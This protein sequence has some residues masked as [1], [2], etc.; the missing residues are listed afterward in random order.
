MAVG[1][2]PMYY[3]FAAM[4][5]TDARESAAGATVKP[6]RGRERNRS[7][8]R[9]NDGARIDATESLTKVGSIDRLAGREIM[10]QM[11]SVNCELLV[12]G[13]GPCGSTAAAL[14]RK[15][16]LSVILAEKD[17][18]PRFHIGE[19][20]LPMANGIL[21]ESGAWPKV[22][23]TGFVDKFGAR[24]C[25]ADG[26]AK[27]RIDFS[28]GLV[29]GLEQT[30][31]VERAKFDHILLEHARS[32]GVDV[33]QDRKVT[34]L[35]QSPHGVSAVLETADGTRESVRARWCIDASGRENHFASAMKRE[36]DPPMLERRVAVYSHFSG[37]PRESGPEG[38]DTIVVRL[39]DGWFWI[40]P[41]DAVKTSV[42]LVT[43]IDAMRANGRD[44]EVVFRQAVADSPYLRERFAPAQAVMSFHVTADYSYFRK[45]LARDRIVL[46]GD[47]GGFF[48]PIF[49][50]GVY[51][52]L[53]SASQAVAMIVRAHASGRPIPARA[54]ARY[55]RR[56]K[57]HAGVFGRL[58]RSFYDGPSFSIFMTPR[59]PFDVE[60]GIN[61]IVAGHARLIWPLRW[62]LHLF[63]FF[64]WLN[65]HVNLAPRLSIA[66]RV[67]NSEAEAAAA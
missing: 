64:C 43:T 7:M 63:L 37:L 33:R 58:I 22:A 44:P 32:E 38:G 31:Q 29:P 42:G 23:A 52:A 47:A 14:A 61:S 3:N 8:L 16:G 36:L 39:D 19:S 65:R 17:A 53:W 59:P 62:R 9:L 24:F 11:Q 40:I 6:R 66:S 12:I 46:A 67:R 57:R 54:C 45:E 30:F 5:V 27:K 25:I 51:M 20:L 15:S 55:S 50:S 1:R 4:A 18:F 21:R 56:I 34:A 35:E 60:R 10:V 26:V 2:M 41:I 48:D 49:S 28:R 13:G